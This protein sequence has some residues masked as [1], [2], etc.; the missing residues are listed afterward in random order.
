M[1]FIKEILHYEPETGVFTWLVSPRAGWVG[2]RAGSLRKDRYRAIK[3]RGVSYLEHRLA[4]FYV[5]GYWPDVIDHIN[6]DEADNRLNN[7]RDCDQFINHQNRRNA[8]QYAYCKRDKRWIVAS[9]KNGKKTV[10]GRF[11]L[12]DEAKQ[13]AQNIGIQPQTGIRADA[14]TV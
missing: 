13:C 7:L 4:W 5:H 2:K 1:D 6:H 3:I 10:Y 11:K 14:P 8:R 9:T 12:E